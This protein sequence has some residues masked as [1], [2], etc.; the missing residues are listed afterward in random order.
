MLIFGLLLLEWPE[1]EIRLWEAK[2]GHLYIVAVHT[3][4]PTYVQPD[5]RWQH[6]SGHSSEKQLSLSAL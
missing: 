3:E 2:V 1:V 5:L 6:G 4:L